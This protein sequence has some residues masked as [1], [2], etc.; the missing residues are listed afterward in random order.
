MKGHLGVSG[1]G[2]AQGV[3]KGAAHSVVMPDLC[4]VNTQY[5]WSLAAEIRRVC[6]ELKT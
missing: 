5:C 3:P 6:S 2:H 4:V 1:L